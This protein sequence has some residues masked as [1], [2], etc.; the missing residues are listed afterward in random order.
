MKK[1]YKYCAVALMATTLVSCED[2]LDDNRD[3]LDAQINNPEFWNNASN[4]E[5]QC[6]TLYNNWHGYGRGDSYG[7]FYYD[8]LNDDQAGRNFANWANTSVPEAST[9]YSSPFVE[10]RRCNYII[11]NVRTSTLSVS[12]KAKFEGIARANRAWQYY[13]LVR[14][15]GDIQ[16]INIVVDPANTAVVYGARDDRDMVMDSVL[17][18]INYAC[19]TL[20]AGTKGT[21]SKA[22]AQAMK[23]DITLWEGTFCKYRTQAENGKAADLNRAD[24]YLAECVKACEAVMGMGY[25]LGDDYQATYNSVDLAGNPEIIFYKK[26]VNTLMYHSLIAYTCSSTQI[27]GMSKDAFDAYLFKDGK[28]KA[29]TTYDTN[30]EAVFPEYQGVD[31]DGKPIKIS[32]EYSIAHLLSVRDA[33]LSKITDPVIYFN[34]QTWARAGAMEMTSSTGY[35]CCKYDN[36]SLPLDN[37]NNTNKNY[38]SAPIFWLAVIYCNYAEAK[39][40]LG[41]LT[42]ADLDAT[43][44]KLMARAELP[45]MTIAGIKPD[46]ANN[47]GVSDLIWEIRRCRRCELMF[48][49]K[50]RYWD[51]VR[52]HQLDKL[53]SS[54]YPNILLGANISQYINYVNKYNADVEVYNGKVEESKRIEK[55]TLPLNNGVYVDG[56]KGLTR[57]YEAR[58]YLYPIPSGQITLNE[59]LTQN[60]L[61]ASK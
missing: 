59:N 7:Q 45:A 51:M 17:A 39:A 57:I 36:T 32:A 2:F 8:A 35:G 11:N 1:L 24:A 21:W 5:G 18:D 43:I 44:N 16:W 61:W 54:K 40:E 53:D 46:P 47:M 4:V 38:T 28:P 56:S 6:N 31:A 58:Q 30:D 52:W 37:R 19:A 10:I 41:T 55:I 3:P 34:G 42:D 49:N 33:R 25:S 27:N 15:Y 9:D 50:F 60:P 13:Q 20:P 22:M 48:D 23:A 14:K 29:L 12:D 26:Y